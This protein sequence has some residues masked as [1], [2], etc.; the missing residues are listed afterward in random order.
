[1]IEIVG[2]EKLSIDILKTLNLYNKNNTFNVAAEL[3]SDHNQLSLS[4]IDII[5]FGV[6]TNQIQHRETFEGISLLKQ[7]DKAIQVFERYYQYEEVSGYSRVKKERIPN[8]AFREALANA[9]VH[10]DWNIHSHIQIALFD[11]YIE[12]NS[13]G[14]LPFGMTEESYLHEQ[15][16]NLRNP[17]IASVFN[18]L[19]L[20]EA[21][22]TGVRRIKDAYENSY[23]KPEFHITETNIKIILPLYQEELPNLVEEELAI[24]HVLQKNEASSRIDIESATGFERS[25]VLRNIKT[26]INKDLV[27]RIGSGPSTSYRLKQ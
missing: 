4:G 3:L 11:N 14:G 19:N 9:I 26:L 8:T 13:P 25:K 20:I 7:Y 10:R 27:A 22:G 15:V 6:N 12:I 5:K 2:I 23:S 1:M 17:I 18:R 16:S 21:F 24:Y